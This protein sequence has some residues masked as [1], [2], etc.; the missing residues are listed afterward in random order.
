MRTR[1][2]GAGRIVRF[3]AAISAIFALRSISEPVAWPG[4]ELGPMG[5]E[6]AV[7]LGMRKELERIEDDAER[8]KTVRD[9][10]EMAL[11]N[12]KAL[13]A[14]TLFEIDD[15]IDPADTRRVVSATFAAA[16]CKQHLAD[17]KV[18]RTLLILD[19]M[20]LNPNGKILKKEL[21]PVMEKAAQQRR[22]S[23][24]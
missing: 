18:P 17:N 2:E 19:T 16:F 21:A 13:N 15:V 14:A 3:H 1:V 5:L 7:R 6:G 20:P 24:A 4:A 11:E 10:T 22:K 8:E 9:L 23:A 12:A